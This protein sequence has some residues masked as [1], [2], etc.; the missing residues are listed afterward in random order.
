[1]VHRPVACLPSAR[2][3]VFQAEGVGTVPPMIG[4]GMINGIDQRVI[5]TVIE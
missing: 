4:D 1:M 5:T 2:R 3:F